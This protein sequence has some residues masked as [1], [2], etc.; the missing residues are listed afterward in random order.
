MVQKQVPVQVKMRRN[1]RDVSDSVQRQ[2][3]G[4]QLYNREQTTENQMPQ[5]QFQN[6]KQKQIPVQIVQKKIG[7]P[8]VQLV[9]ETMRSENRAHDAGKDFRRAR[10]SQSGRCQE[11]Q[12]CSQSL[13][14]RVSPVRD[15]RYLPSR[16]DQ[17][18]QAMEMQAEADRRKR[19]E[20]LH[21]E[22]DEQSEINK[23]GTVLLNRSR[24]TQDITEV[25]D[26]TSKESFNQVK[27]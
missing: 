24:S 13:K 6:V 19:A 14:H 15:S 8:Q 26:V 11:R 21:S 12:R 22:G 18:R 9:Q 4:F 5:V 16:L 10:S 1:S 23:I 20:H 2:N 17:E 25:Y 27:I 7:I 3:G